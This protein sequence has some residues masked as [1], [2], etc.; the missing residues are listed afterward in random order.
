MKKKI[1]IYIGIILGFLVLAYAFVPQVLG[2]KVLNQSDIS[3]WRG[4]VQE[5][6]SWNRE[7]PDDKTAWTGS[8]FGGMPTASIEASTEGDWTRHL[9][10]ALM[11]GKRP[12]NWLFVSLLGGFL[13]MLAFGINPLLAVGGAVAITF[14]S[15]N[16]Q[17][18]QVGH[19]TKMQAIALMPWVLAALVFSYKSAIGKKRRRQCLEQRFSAWR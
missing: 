14:C 19:N 9:Y 17:I 4:M 10:N 13:L 8:M 15:F 12:A 18:I 11:T 6:A 7:H 1:T 16:M 5:S 2:G 3:G